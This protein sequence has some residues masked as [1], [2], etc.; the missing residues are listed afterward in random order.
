VKNLKSV[1]ESLRGQVSG[2]FKDEIEESVSM[3]SFFFRTIFR[4][5]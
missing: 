5:S 2:K 4:V 3:V 1:L